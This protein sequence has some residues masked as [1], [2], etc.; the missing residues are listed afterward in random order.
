VDGAVT[1][2]CQAIRLK[3][4]LAQPHNNLG[5]FLHDKGDVDGANAEYREALRLRNSAEA[6]NNLGNALKDK[7][8]LEAA[9]TECHEALRLKPN[10]AGAHNTLGI[11]LAIKGDLEGAIAEFRAAL[12]LKK[13]Y[14]EAHNNLGQALYEKG[15]FAEALVHFRRAQEL[16]LKHPRGFSPSA[17][18]VQDCEPFVE[19]DPKL[20]ALLAGKGRP[21]SAEEGVLLARLCQGHRRLYKAAVGFYADAFREKPDL[22]DDLGRQS[23]YDAACAA[24]LAAAGQGA[25]AQALPEPERARLRQQALYWLRGELGA[26]RAQLG[27]GTG[28]A[29]AAVVMQL[30]HWLADP[31]FAGVRGPEALKKLPEAERRRWQQ[32]WQDV[33]ALR[34]R[35]A[36]PAPKAGTSHP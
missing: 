34:Q 22:A 21:S 13:D 2:Y 6:H 20:P 32:L 23:R 10:Y 33:E 18:R 25:D 16:S 7:G 17:Q 3:R 29:R 1:E 36:A 9:I 19:L 8:Q 28:Q 31:D 30:Q 24:A 35:A 15:K 4:D 14:V 26:W 27:Q 11:A 5:N 12:R